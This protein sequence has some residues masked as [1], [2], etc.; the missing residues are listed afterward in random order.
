MI[1]KNWQNSTISGDHFVPAHGGT[2]FL[3]WLWRNWL[4]AIVYEILLKTCLPRRIDFITWADRN[5]HEPHYLKL[6]KINPLRYI[7][8][9]STSFWDVA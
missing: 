2:D 6:T 8:R 4:D 7:M 9:C 1:L 3:P 5:Y